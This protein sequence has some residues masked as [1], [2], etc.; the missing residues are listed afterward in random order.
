VA[1]AF[2]TLVP[3]DVD[4]AALADEMSSL[5]AQA[6]ER[7]TQIAGARAR[8]EK[9]QAELAKAPERPPPVCPRGLGLKI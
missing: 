3:Q 1:S 8:L 4:I 7:A 6:R 2:R 9:A 5:E